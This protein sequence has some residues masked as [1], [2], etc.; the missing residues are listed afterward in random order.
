MKINYGKQVKV[1][2]SGDDIDCFKKVIEKLDKESKSIGFNKITFL[3]DSEKEFVTK[4]ND[5]L[6]ED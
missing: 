1:K 4:L 3:S 6:N 2:F 5:K